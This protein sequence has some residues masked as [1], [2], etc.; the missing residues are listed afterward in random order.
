MKTIPSNIV[1]AYVGAEMLDLVLG[2]CNY[3]ASGNGFVLVDMDQLENTQ[4]TSGK[5][6]EMTEEISKQ[7]LDWHQS[8][9]SESV[10]GRYNGLILLRS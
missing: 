1:T 10:N 2:T 8:L 9:G 6:G 7:V 5:V 3:E 4:D